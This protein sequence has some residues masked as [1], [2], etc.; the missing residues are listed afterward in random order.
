MTKNY[1]VQTWDAD[2]SMK[3]HYTVSIATDA[4]LAQLRKF[5]KAKASHVLITREPDSPKPKTKGAKTK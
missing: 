3:N 5:L 4:E 2:G 1:L